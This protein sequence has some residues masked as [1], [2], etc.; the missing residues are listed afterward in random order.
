MKKLVICVLALGLFS[1]SSRAINI[2]G[3]DNDWAKVRV[4]RK[5]SLRPLEKDRAGFDMKNIKLLLGN[6][7]L[8]IYIDGKSVTGLKPDGG[9]GLKKTS[10]RVSFKSEPSPLNRVRIAADPDAPW[11]VKLSYPSITSEVLGSQNNKYWA[12]IRGKK[13]EVGFEIKVPVYRTQKGIQVGVPSGPLIKTF[14]SQGSLS[15][16]QINSV[17]VVTHRLVDTVEFPIHRGDL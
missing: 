12:F 15:D 1:V 9:A 6:G 8:Y 5:C 16:V 3:R 2:D 4:F 14:G 11:Q 7:F 10:I 13:K 17:D